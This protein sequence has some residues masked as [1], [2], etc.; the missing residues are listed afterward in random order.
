MPYGRRGSEFAVSKQ[1]VGNQTAPSV[2]GFAEG[3]FI[4][5]WSTTDTLQDGAG[6]AIKAQRYDAV[7]NAVGQEVLINSFSAGDQ[8]APS[9]TTLA[10]GGYVVTWESTDPAQDG[11][12]LA[13][14]GQLF[15]PSGARVGS[16]FL[17]NSQS[18]SDQILSSVTGL[19]GG[20][21]VVTWST[22]DATQDGM[23]SAIKGQIYSAAGVAVGGEFLVN[24]GGL[25]HESAPSVTSL[26]GGGF[27]A[28]WT[29]GS[30]TN[31][32]IYAQVFDPAGA[33][34]GSEFLVSTTSI[35]NQD[36]AS[37]SEISGG[38]FVVT[39]MHDVNLFGIEMQIRARIF[40]AD[41]RRRR[42]SRHPAYGHRH[43]HFLGFRAVGARHPGLDPGP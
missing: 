23:G 7:G 19:E 4:V 36:L 16:E 18:A 2:A 1:I 26:S 13:I 21:F 34:I 24:S 31:A 33:K 37:V 41:G 35:N 39:W 11:S 30:G 14:K 38:R 29:R 43:P 25:G 28:T 5:V 9:V 22:A 12:G 10:N 42:R 32:D 6:W 8:R 27:V 3:G 40:S 15:D 17:V 20:G